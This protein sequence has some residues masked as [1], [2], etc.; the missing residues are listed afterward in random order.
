MWL[1]NSGGGGW[2]GVCARV[3][4]LV[5]FIS[6]VFTV[7]VYLIFQWYERAK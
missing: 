7:Y 4:V 2:G 6:I 1:W 3:P 5:F